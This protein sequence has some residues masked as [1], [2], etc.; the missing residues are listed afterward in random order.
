MRIR[1]QE[2]DNVEVQ[3]APLIDIVF[4]LLIFFLLTMT[5]RKPDQPKEL[6]GEPPRELPLELPHSAAAVVG[7]Q[8]E[9]VLI[10]SIDK[11]GNKYADLQPVTTALLHQRVKDAA[12]K[13]PKQRVRIDADRATKYED[14][15]EVIELC[16]FEGLRN[17]GLHTAPE[18]AMPFVPPGGLPPGG[19][20]AA[21]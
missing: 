18:R 9:D 12:R 11:D 14:V 13:N 21:P 17:V 6:P 7:P 1:R 19:L 4:L 8:P 5:I 20:R 2:A 3:M 16:Q 15:I 10:L